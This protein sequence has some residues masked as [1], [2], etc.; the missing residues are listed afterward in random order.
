[1]ENNIENNVISVGVQD[2]LKLVI[3]GKTSTG[4][5]RL[6]D[7]LSSIGFSCATKLTTNPNTKHLYGY[8]YIEKEALEAYPD[9]EIA[10]RGFIDEYPYI[11]TKEEIKNCSFI[12]GSL[13]DIKN[14]SIT[15]PNLFLYTVYL[16]SDFKN[17]M[18]CHIKKGLTQDDFIRVFED[19]EENYEYKLLDFIIDNV[20]AMSD[21][22]RFTEMHN[23]IGST[24]YELDKINS[25]DNSIELSFY[26]I[27]SKYEQAN[28][29][30]SMLSFFSENDVVS[31][32]RKDKVTY[33]KVEMNEDM[34]S[35]LDQFDFIKNDGAVPLMPFVFIMA[36]DPELMTA[37]NNYLVYL[38]VDKY[39]NLVMSNVATN[40]IDDIEKGVNNNHI[41]KNGKKR[42]IA[43]SIALAKKSISS[44]KLLN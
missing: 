33:M 35:L 10:C 5:H 26:D 31:I 37:F 23:I 44:E 19:E 27:A 15:L 6:A 11:I 16:S 9:E 20:N 32:Y 43:D 40:L 21:M 7:L 4:K 2:E 38:S 17:R 25:N 18:A 22:T 36:S 3:M 41:N 30:L 24:S 34:S 39:V 29:L 8:K 1:M 12:I 14:I 42:K 13:S 28:I